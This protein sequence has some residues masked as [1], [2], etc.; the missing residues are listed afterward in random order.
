MPP[1]ETGTPTIQA[2]ETSHEIIEALRELDQPTVTD[3]ATHI[4][5]SKGGVFKHLK[6]LQKSGFVI[7]E[8]NQYR[9]GLRFLD[10]GGELRYSHP[11]SQTI[12]EKMKEL[13]EE[14]DETSIY[15]VLD[16]TKT[17][18]LY[19][20]TGSRGVSTRTRIGKRLY[21]H[22]TAAGKSIL[23]QLPRGEVEDIIDDVG[24]PP[25]TENTITEKE[26]FI[27]ELDTVRERGYAYNLGESVEGLVA[28]AVP[29]VPNG[30]VMGA[31]SVTG[32][33]HRMKEDPINEEITDTLLSFV[34]EL[35]LNIAHS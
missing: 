10:I 18:T 27:E 30:E 34:N 6:T 35:E 14:T 1:T 17:T 28:M 21:P 15:T 26:R 20:E 2:V 24:L 11:R 25:I 5:S 31:C 29:L 32:P 13:A 19:R 7:R 33:Y 12:K 23:S 4:E 22:E 8:G 16:D 9:L 3:V